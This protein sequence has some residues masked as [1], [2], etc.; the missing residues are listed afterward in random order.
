MMLVRRLTEQ[1]ITAR[2]ASIYFS[3]K[4]IDSKDPLWTVT[5]EEVIDFY[6]KYWDIIARRKIDVYK[7]LFSDSSL[8]PAPREEEIA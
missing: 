7:D 1:S 2:E 8:D 5:L 6:D 4:K 3:A